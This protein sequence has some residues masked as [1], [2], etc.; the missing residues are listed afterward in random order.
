M[1]VPTARGRNGRRAGCALV[2]IAALGWGAAAASAVEEGGGSG[3]CGCASSRGDGGASSGTCS[4][5][6]GGAPPA[7][8]ESAAAA[9][10][11]RAANPASGR[12]LAHLKDVVRV[13]AGWAVLGTDAAHFQADAESPSFPFRLPAPLLVDKYE[14][15][16]AR[17]AE[18]VAA[19]GYATEAEAYGWSFVHELAVPPA[20]AA[21]INQSVAGVEWW[22]PVPNASWASPEGL[23]TTVEGREDHPALHISKRDADAFCTW[24]GGRLPSEGE[25]EYAAR[26]GK[27]GRTYAWG[28]AMMGKA[29]A[30][31]AGA[32]ALAGASTHR[33]NIWQG[34][35][36]SVNTGEDGHLWAAPVDA[37]GPQNAWGLHNV[38][39]NVWE[40]TADT[41]CP[42]VQPDGKYVAGK[43]PARR[44]VP[45]D[46][47]RISAQAR[48]AMMNDPGEV[49][50][51]KKGGS[52]MCHKD[53]CYR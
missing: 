2:V 45:S 17:F 20:I 52:F 41:W 15:S 7:A 53:Y 13:P 25:W 11:R 28:N 32:G 47:Q 18:F 21:G 12:S 3:D 42:N 4:A 30:A 40:W 19:T 39:G 49:D 50:F 35:F 46:C 6:G 31:G 14:V 10:A 24:A 43:K 37:F 33:M 36:P 34:T 9:A 5:G 29:A 48:K 1:R 23:G 27:E 16:N 26:G 8:A 38:I 22:L 51:V 44:S